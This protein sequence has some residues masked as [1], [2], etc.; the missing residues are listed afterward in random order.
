MAHTAREKEKILSRINRMKGQLDAVAKALDGD[1]DCYEIMRLLASCRG[2]IN[3]LM[4]DVIEGHIRDHI[5]QAETKK[6]AA[7]SGEEIIEIMKSFWK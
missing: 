3:G 5:V 4:G 2:A 1:R 7:Q 6:D